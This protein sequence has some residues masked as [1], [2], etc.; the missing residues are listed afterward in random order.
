VASRHPEQRFEEI[1]ERLGELQPLNNN[2]CARFAAIVVPHGLDLAARSAGE[3]DAAVRELLEQARWW[4]EDESCW[5]WP[6]NWWANFTQ[7]PSPELHRL[8]PQEL[9]ALMDGLDSWMSECW[10]LMNQDDPQEAAQLP[11]L[12]ALLRDLLGAYR[13][14]VLDGQDAIPMLAY[15]HRLPFDDDDE[16]LYGYLI[17]VGEQRLGILHI[18][19]SV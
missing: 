3:A 15:H 18:D 7:G 6:K 5:A 14:W 1:A 19:Y 17:L 4:F 13:Q 16:E 2:D 9:T 10:L 11:R 8:D 12:Q